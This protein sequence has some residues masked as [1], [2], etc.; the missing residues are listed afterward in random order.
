[1]RFFLISISL[2]AWSCSAFANPQS[3]VADANGTEW[4]IT[5]EKGASFQSILDALKNKHRTGGYDQSKFKIIKKGCST[6]FLRMEEIYDACIIDKLPSGA[7]STLRY[8]V[9]N[10]CDRISCNPNFYEKL[11]Y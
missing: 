9:I 4:L 1:M 5:H 10:V 6:E 8:S 11:K 7:K 2:L 3:V